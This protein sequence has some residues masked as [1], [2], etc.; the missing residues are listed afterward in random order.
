MKFVYIGLFKNKNNDYNKEYVTHIL[1]QC[2]SLITI[3]SSEYE[4]DKLNKIISE[5]VPIQTWIFK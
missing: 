3:P 1:S 4:G 2:N 5:G